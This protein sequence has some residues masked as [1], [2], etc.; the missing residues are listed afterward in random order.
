MGYQFVPKGFKAPYKEEHSKFT[1]RKLTVDEVD[2]D[3]EAVMS[4]RESLRQIFCEND[5]WP[6][7]DMTIE[8]NYEDLLEHQKEFDK[9]IG[10]AYTVVTPDDSK[11][12]GCLYIYPFSLGVYDSRIYYWLVDEVAQ[13]LDEGFRGFL[14]DWIPDTFGLKNPVFPGRDMSHQEWDE[15]VKELRKGR[16]RYEG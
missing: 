9:N 2:K 7:D 1:L 8:E 5:D 3:Y 12:I 14:D 16:E 15:T 6:S 13:K 10:F 11:C 4:S